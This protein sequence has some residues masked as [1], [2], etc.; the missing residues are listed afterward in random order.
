MLHQSQ[1]DDVTNEPEALS[2]TMELLLALGLA[3]TLVLA[4]A[5]L[6]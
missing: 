1:Y 5:Y 2:V 4:V 6:A 3:A